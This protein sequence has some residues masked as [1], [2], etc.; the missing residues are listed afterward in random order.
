M[1]DSGI[2]TD[3]QRLRV[4]L[5]L[6]PE[7][8]EA[9]LQGSYHSLNIDDIS[10]RAHV[11]RET[12]AEYL[13]SPTA[14]KN[15]RLNPNRLTESQTQSIPEIDSARVATV[16]EGRPYFSMA[17]LQAATG[18]DPAVLVELF[19][20]PPWRFPDPLANREVTFDH[21][22]NRF[23]V[24]PALSF[25]A[26]PIRSLGYLEAKPVP[27]GAMRLIVPGEFEQTEPPHILK[28]ELRGEVF[29]VLRDNQGFERM[30]APGLLDVWF[31]RSVPEN[32]ARG[33]L[34]AFG[35][36]VKNA[37][38]RVGYYLAELRDRPS[39][40]D[41]TRA[42]FEKVSELSERD[43]V[44]FAEPAQGS[45][46]SFDQRGGDSGPDFVFPV[47]EFEDASAGSRGWNAELI[48]AHQAHAITTG[49]DNVTIFIVDSGVRLNHPD[50]AAALRSDWSTLDLNFDAAV[51][52]SETSPQET[53][54]AH[55]T[56]VS[57]IA[58]G[59]AIDFELGARGMAPS[60]P[61]L[62]VK[63]SGTMDLT[64]YGFRAAAILDVAR[65]LGADE[66]GVI[67]L[68]WSTEG[69]H[70]G[71]REALIEATQ[72][73]I[74][75]VCSAGNYHVGE[76]QIPNRLHYPSKYAFL[77]GDTDADV[78]ARSKIKGVCSVAAVNAS[79][80]KASYSYY[81]SNA[82]SICAPGGEPGGVGSGVFVASTPENY[83]Y[84]AGTSYAAP[85]VAGVIGLMFTIDSSLSAQKA[86]DI[87]RQTAENIDVI[88]PTY[89]GMLGG[90]VNA[91]AALQ[92]LRGATGLPLD[93]DAS[94]GGSII[95]GEAPTT[96]TP[97]EGDRVDINSATWQQLAVLP[98]IG[99]WSANT[100]VA[101]RDAHGP[102]STIWDLTTT[103][104]VDNWT[105]E[106]IQHLI[107]AGDVPPPP[108]IPDSSNT[109]TATTNTNAAT[110]NINIATLEQFE[111][112]PLIGRWSAEQ[113][114]SYRSLHG[115]FASVSDLTL[116]GAVD[117]W[118]VQRLEMQIRV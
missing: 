34:A 32:Q 14:L 22:P 7:E 16:L 102:F 10:R 65:Q 105:I 31:Q 111:A 81:G 90:L 20:I 9:A 95:P 79:R 115:P 106:Q 84:G 42:V 107:F 69:E 21:V 96:A 54:I 103:G 62:P 47:L 57:G 5:Q 56:R 1:P 39:D 40:K 18:I 41:T 77:P 108:P 68:S 104:A 63:I 117:R 59:R 19:R 38:P 92:H 58:A 11:D 51:A 24:G 50:L 113:I 30:F 46:D 35:L 64:S 26:D 8:I 94:S 49:S 91:R 45:L 37:R 88:N 23:L 66:R 73:G 100:I 97:N 2:V 29:P 12:V 43:D 76:T 75:V 67:N 87:L 83:V 116:T 61:V 55:G 44:R 101:Y 110:L 109:N 98:L 17:E 93:G 78:A 52:E 53:G 74:A 86:I 3:R 82:V 28:R 89:A 6:Q 4:F 33:V 80:S 85:H 99:E 70:I 112:L 114:I 48:E 13:S 118:T 25:E 60:C 71:I 36:S 72:S 27:P 15:A